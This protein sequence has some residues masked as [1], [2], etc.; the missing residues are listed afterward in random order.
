MPLD[1]PFSPSLM[2]I[3]RQGLYADAVTRFSLPSCFACRR[4]LPTRQ[5]RHAAVFYRRYAVTLLMLPRRGDT[6]ARL[7]ARE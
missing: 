2:I 7:A 6:R 3:Y 1:T 4:A 5:F